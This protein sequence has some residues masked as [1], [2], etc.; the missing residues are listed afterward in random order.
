MAET[1]L[2]PK[3]N[4]SGE[5]ESDDDVFIAA[6]VEGSIDTSRS[7]EIE[8]GAEVRGPLSAA[9]IRV[10]GTVIGALV[11]KER[12]ELASSGAVIGDL[13]APRMTISDGARFEGTVFMDRKA[14]DEADEEDAP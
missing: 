5:I 14:G 1:Y 9:R 2:G 4:L 12:I 11:A 13:H 7:L 10:V 3:L 8:R 6:K